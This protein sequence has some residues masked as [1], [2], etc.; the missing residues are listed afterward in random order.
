MR[1]AVVA[2]LGDLPEVGERADPVAGDGEEVVEVLA[3]ALNPLDVNVGAGRFYGGHPPLPYVPGAEGVGRIDG[4]HVWVFGAGIGTQ[5]DGTVAERVAAPRDALSPVPDGADPAVAAALGIGGVSGWLPLVSRAPVRPGETVVVLGAT[6]AVGLIAV[7][8]AKLLGAANVIAVGR[9]RD[10][11]ER[12]EELGADATV[13]LDDAFGDALQDACP[14][15]ADLIF[16]ALWGEPLETALSVAKPGARIVHMG[17]S[18]GATATLPSSTVRGKQLEILGY[19]TFAAPRDVLAREYARLVEH[20]SAGRIVVD[21][22]RVPLAD[23][24]AAWQ[25]QASGDATKIVVVP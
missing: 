13:V 10:R 20:V 16:D 12:A 19:S 2:R 14:H 11:L 22:E 4:R 6:G 15:G 8:T 23:V 17:Q 9:R 24:A 7:Q 21:F 1:A 5:R 18:A 3:A 25:R